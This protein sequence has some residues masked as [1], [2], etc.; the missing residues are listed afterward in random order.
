MAGVR[1]SICSKFYNPE[2]FSEC[3]FCSAESIS[4]KTGT[5]NTSQVSVPV[6]QTKD[7]AIDALVEKALEKSPENEGKTVSF[8]GGF[9]NSD[10]QATEN[11]EADISFNQD[12]M[13]SEINL[14]EQDDMGNS[15]GEIGLSAADEAIPEK[16]FDKQETQVSIPE[17]VTERNKISNTASSGDGKT[18]GYFKS[19]KSE[20][21][22]SSTQEQQPQQYVK[23]TGR[24]VVGWLVCVKGV[25]FG[26][27]FE[28]F[29]GNNSLGRFP[30]NDIVITDDRTVSRNSHIFIIFDAK[31]GDY[32]I[33]PG[34][35]HSIPRINDNPVL[36]VMLMN[37]FDVIEIGDEKFV[38]VPLCGKDFDW[39]KFINPE[40]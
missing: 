7:S 34:T 3:P 26:E 19:L 15:V 2:R 22:S 1:C 37:A 5:E 18:W 25:H 24:P 14:M 32:Y 38:F 11:D 6:S 13:N 8:F 23:K 40:E 17:A 9:V 29:E 33:K 27:S 35:S 20:T 39:R 12:A 36:E 31:K 30:E 4:K 28:F 10:A 16:T 21:L